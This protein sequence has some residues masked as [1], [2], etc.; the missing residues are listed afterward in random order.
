MSANTKPVTDQSFAADVL[1]AEGP[2]AGGFLGGVVRPLQDDRPG[3]GGDSRA[4][5]PAS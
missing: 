1:K 3:A 2:G 4:S 5:S